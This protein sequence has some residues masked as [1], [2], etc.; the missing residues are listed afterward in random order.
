[1]RIS[2]KLSTT[3]VRWKSACSIKTK[4]ETSE[5]Q[6]SAFG[7]TAL[8]RFTAEIIS[9][10]VVTTSYHQRRARSQRFP[11][12]ADVIN[13]VFA[14]AFSQLKSRRRRKNVCTERGE[15]RTVLGNDEERERVDRRASDKT[16]D[17]P[18]YLG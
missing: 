8:A 18:R 15:R 16:K 3:F 4:Q 2:V 5:T 10:T 1:M 12:D 6:S 13:Y 7:N 11:V 14:S 9:T 17:A